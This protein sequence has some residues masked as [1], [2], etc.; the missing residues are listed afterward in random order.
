M[1]VLI[2]GIAGHMGREVLAQ[3]QNE[4]VCGVDPAGCEFS[5]VPCAPSF[6]RAD[7]DVDCIIDFSHHSNTADLL[8]F[9]VKHRLPLVLATTGQT[10]EEKQQISA[11]AKQIPLFFVANYSIG[12][13]LLI[14]LAKKAA[15]AL[16][17]ATKRMLR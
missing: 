6:D 5:G 13:V 17:E 15:A 3:L 11:A 9:A 4:T 2:S 12:V 1:K 10:D 16:P 14:E 8:A 7:A